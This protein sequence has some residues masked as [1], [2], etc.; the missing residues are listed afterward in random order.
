MPEMITDIVL[1]R[2]EGGAPDAGRRIVVDTKFTSIVGRGRFGRQM[3]KSGHMYQLYA[4][5]R[6][7]EQPGEPMT[8]RSSGVLLYPSLGVDCNESAVIQGHR[9]SFA[10]VDLAADSHSIR[11]Q[12][13]RIVES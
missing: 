3:L 11:G 5:L 13:L 2:L 7:Q 10:T 12:L 8:C 4:Y 9:V 1:E 6:S